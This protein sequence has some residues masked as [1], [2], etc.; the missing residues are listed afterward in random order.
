MRTQRVSGY[1][2][3]SRFVEIDLLY[4]PDEAT[5]VVDSLVA[6]YKPVQKHIP[7]R[8]HHVQIGGER[9]LNNTQHYHFTSYQ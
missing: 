4:N 6:Y 2:C 1:Q 3:A 5:E 9:K 8:Q 7:L